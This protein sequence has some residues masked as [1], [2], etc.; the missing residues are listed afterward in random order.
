AANRAAAPFQAWTGAAAR[1]VIPAIAALRADRAC[2]PGVVVAAVLAAAAVVVEAEVVAAAVVVVVA[3]VEA[4][5]R[6][7]NIP[8][9]NSRT[10]KGE[11]NNASRNEQ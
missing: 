8:D 1:R 4:G 3:A 9:I 2:H 7:D 5:D 6:H 10:F 11:K